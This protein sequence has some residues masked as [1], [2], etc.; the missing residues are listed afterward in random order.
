MAG[1]LVF[2]TV[3]VVVTFALM[4]HAIGWNTYGIMSS[5]FW[6]YFVAPVAVFPYP[7][8]IAA[9]EFHSKRR[10]AG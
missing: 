2:T 7:G 5:A 6:L 10:R 3:V 9:I 8:T 1:A 4:A